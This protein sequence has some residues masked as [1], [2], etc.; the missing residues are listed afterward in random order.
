M[1]TP[2]RVRRAGSKWRLLVHDWL[3]KTQ[4]TYASAVEGC[5]YELVWK[6]PK[7]PSKLSI[8]IDNGPGE[9]AS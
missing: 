7:S 6:D 5:G 4:D 9:R 8:T 1:T 2:N 3:G